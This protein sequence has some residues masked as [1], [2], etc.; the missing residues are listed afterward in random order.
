M[1]HLEVFVDTVRAGSFSSVARRRGVAVSSIARQIDALEEELKASLF[2][3][4]TRA[5]RPTDAGELLFR[6]AI[7]ILSD[8]ADARSE[9]NSFESAVAGV[10]R[11]SCLPTFGRKYVVPCLANLFESHPR[12]SVELDLTERIAD[13]TTERIDLAIRFGDLPDSALISTKL[14][15]QCYVLCAAP[16]YLKRHGPLDEVEQLKQHRL[17]DKRRSQSVLGWR[18]ILCEERLQHGQCVFEADDFDAQR[19]LAVAGCGIVRLPD[20]VVGHDVGTGALVQMQPAW[21]AAPKV[22]GIHLVRALP[23]PS[24]RLKVFVDALTKFVGRPA[25]WQSAMLG[26]EH[27]AARASL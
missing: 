24:A 11:V 6:R 3:R 2:T 9:V 1:E 15:D 10:L 26:S 22:S 5:L 12:L 27:R 17:I 8:L 4:S 25:S 19:Q 23:R 21:L 7:Q 14:A 16:A 20:W 18:E 13:P